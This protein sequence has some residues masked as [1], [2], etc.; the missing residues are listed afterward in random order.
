MAEKPIFSKEAFIKAK[1]WRLIENGV[2]SAGWNMS[3]DEALLSSFEE[4]DL[5]I[6]RLYRWEDAL[7]LGRF[8]QVSTSLDSSKVEEAKLACVRRMTGGGVLLHG[9]DLCYTLIVPRTF[10]RDK[11]VKQSYRYLCSFLIHLYK[12]L[13]YDASFAIENEQQ[14]HRNEVCLAGKEAFDIVI[15]GK[16]IGGNAQ[17]YS[18]CVLMQQ[19]SIPVQRYVPEYKSLFLGDSGLD[20]AA[21]LEGLGSDFR[22]EAL[23]LLLTESFCTSF[24][25]KLTSEKLR[26]AEEQ[27]AM[28]LLQEKYSRPGWNLKESG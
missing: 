4:G 23:A 24:G 8:S 5:P 14:L 15:E 2:G 16:K 18:R 26:S 12:R 3:V 13:G 21:T 10:L 17:R 20:E 7:S 19:G 25:V 1:A 28:Q 22:Y 11:G 27:R 9:K 6:L